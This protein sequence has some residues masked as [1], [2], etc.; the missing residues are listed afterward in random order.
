M[1]DSNRAV[2]N[3][4]SIL[5]IVMVLLKLCLVFLSPFIISVILVIILEPFVKFI[6]KF[7]I[8]RRLGVIISFALLLVIVL[9]MIYYL[10]SITYNQINSLLNKLPD[11]FAML[12]IRFKFMDS[13][14]YNYEGLINTIENVLPKYKEKIIGTIISTASGAVYIIIIS[15]VT[16]FLSIDLY[17][18]TSKAKKY[19]PL[20]IYSILR[21]SFYKT[22]KIINT[23]IKLVAAT[24]MLTIIG[25]YIIG[26]NKPLT[27]GIICGILDLIPVIGPSLIF[28][29]WIIF[30]IV[31]EKY[32]FAIGLLLLY[33]AIQ[34]SRQVMEIKFVG[35][36]LKIH[37][38]VT[39]FSLYIGIIVYGVWGVIFGPFI[40]ILAK[41]IIDKYFERG[42]R[43]II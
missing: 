30:S 16:L 39:I 12:K 10:S 13:V 34:I 41:E 17:K 14:N 2:L 11:I 23:E 33:V 35:N 25:L 42:Y 43:F 15:M 38:L 1:K 19:L 20:E 36:S 31:I 4:I 22:N 5:I 24:T 3:I 6:S 29:P 7:K 18:I 26:A 37:P 9:F 27:I 8:S 21:S 40:V 28:I 32:F